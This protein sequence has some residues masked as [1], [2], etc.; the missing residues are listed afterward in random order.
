[1]KYWNDLPDWILHVTT[2]LAILAVTFVVS[3]LARRGF[4]RFMRKRSEEMQSDITN[5]KFLGNALSGIIYTVGIVLAIREFPP[6]RAA[7]GSLLAGAGILAAVVGFASQQAFSN[8]VSGI[9][10]IIFKPFRVKDRLKVKEIYSGEVEDIT[11]RHTVLRDFE[12][13]R[14]IVP[15]ALIAS[16]I[17]VNS[18]FDDDPVCKFV[19]FGIAYDAD[20]DKA[21]AIMAEEIGNHP[22]YHDRRKPK[23]IE[24]GKPK[25]DVRMVRLEASAVVLRGYAWA[26]TPAEAFDLYCDLLESIKKRFDTEGVIIPY[27]HVVVKSEE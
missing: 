23:E 14:I 11:L 27:P 17:L 22:Q 21:K 1:M 25:V 19:E 7:A 16:E 4:N 6:L 5:Y 10:L 18:D 13:R 9:F 15:N 24:E 12:N 3:W 8:I 20:T 26:K 2:F